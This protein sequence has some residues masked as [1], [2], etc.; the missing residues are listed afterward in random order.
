[1]HDLLVNELNF[2]GIMITDALDMGATKDIPDKFVKA[3]KAG[4]HLLLV[5]DYAR[6][7]TELNEAVKNG[8]ISEDELNKQVFKVL[9]WKY[10]KGLL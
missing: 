3:V 1:V 2:T 6:A 5:Q 9:A 10:Y 4:N 7:Y 8:S